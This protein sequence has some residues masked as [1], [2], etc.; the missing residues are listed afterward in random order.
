MPESFLVSPYCVRVGKSLS[1]SFSPPPLGGHE[2]MK[3]FFEG[4]SRP[5]V[6]VL[7]ETHLLFA[8]RK[9]L[10]LCSSEGFRRFFPLVWALSARSPPPPRLL[11]V[12]CSFFNSLMHLP[13]YLL[14]RVRAPFDRF[15]L[16]RTRV[17][18]R[19]AFLADSWQHCVPLA[20][21]PTADCSRLCFLV[22]F[23]PPP[24]HFE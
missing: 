19:P 21:S 20:A 16:V 22:L 23:P 4:L 9:R 24:P 6:R 13:F 2:R 12:R 5:R 1:L 11:A 8:G 14:W 17:C 7:L 15:R 10:T 18:S 3:V